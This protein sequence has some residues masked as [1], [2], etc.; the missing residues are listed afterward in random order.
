MKTSYIIVALVIG[1]GF[2]IFMNPASA[3][4]Q[5]AQAI[6]SQNAA[7]LNAQ[8]ET[9]K[10]TLVELQKQAGQSQ[11]SQQT[12]ETIVLKNALDNLQLTLKSVQTKIQNDEINP[13][14]SASLNQTLGGVKI[15]LTAINS[16]IAA[17]SAMAAKN[18]KSQTTAINSNSKGQIE[19]QT[20]SENQPYSQPLTALIESVAPAKT[21]SEKIYGKKT[22]FGTIGLIILIALGYFSWMK[23][24]YLIPF[25][26]AQKEKSLTF[27]K[28]KKEKIT[29]FIKSSQ[30]K[31]KGKT[32]ALWKMY[33]E[34]SA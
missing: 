3:S 21:I 33:K 1:F 32:D 18:K 30:E 25:M 28:I 17:K 34:K 16:N 9:M 24:D 5:T 14:I 29:A 20:L 7:I 27:V 23:K 4:A 15:N 12:N 13:E 22:I 8:L 19:S 31:M 26:N 2:G 6:S 10:Q 11:A